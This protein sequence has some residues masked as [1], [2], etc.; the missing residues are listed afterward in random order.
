[1][2]GGHVWGEKSLLQQVVVK[3]NP[4]QEDVYAE[5]RGDLVKEGIFDENGAL[6]QKR[7]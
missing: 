7:I 1:M 3:L 6:T 4:P 2:G 5:V